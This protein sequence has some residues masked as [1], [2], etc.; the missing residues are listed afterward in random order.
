MAASF[1][2]ISELQLYCRFC[3]RV[4]PAQLERSIAG[5]GRTVDKK[6]TFEYICSRCHRTHC[7]FGE[8]IIEKIDNDQ[9][10]TSESEQK[11]REYKLSEHFLIG[12]KITH[13]SYESVGTVVGKDPGI[14][15][16]LL[17]KFEKTIITLVEDIN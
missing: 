14:P 1:T 11:P 17:V 2:P 3:K 9:E 6:S 8:D 5:S 7:F 13:P 10:D 12:E 4:L 15:N 16:R